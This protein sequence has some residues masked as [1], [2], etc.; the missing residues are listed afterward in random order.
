MSSVYI[1]LAKNVF[2]TLHQNPDQARSKYAASSVCLTN[3]QNF[4]WNIETCLFVSRQIL[5]SIWTTTFRSQ[6]HPH[7]HKPNKSQL[8]FV[9][10]V[11][12]DEYTLKLSIHTPQNVLFVNLNRNNDNML[13]LLKQILIRCEA[14]WRSYICVSAVWNSAQDYR[15]CVPSLG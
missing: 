8:V 13:D 6:F 1:C 2:L 10:R 5:R 3:V 12:G 14:M 4:M 7:T 11:W 9:F 15:K